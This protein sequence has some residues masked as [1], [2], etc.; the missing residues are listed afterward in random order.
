M[1]VAK[2]RTTLGIHLL[3]LAAR[4]IGCQLEVTLAGGARDPAPRPSLAAPPVRLSVEDFE[5]GVAP[6]DWSDANRIRIMLDGV[7]MRDVTAYDC[8]AGWIERLRRDR[9]RELVIKDEKLERE[10]VQGAVTVEYRKV[11]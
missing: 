9:Q 2:F 8:E 5:R 7:E 10:R 1:G 4:V 6:V 3:N 11:A